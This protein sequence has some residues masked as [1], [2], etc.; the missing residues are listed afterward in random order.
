MTHQL[1][2]LLLCVATSCLA[3]PAQSLTFAEGA[4]GNLTIVTV[5]ESAPNGA[6]TT[7]LQNVELLPIE[8][9]GR[10]LAQQHDGTRSRRV[11]RH[12]I[13]RVELPG[14]GRVFRYRRASGQ[15][16]GFLQVAADGGARVVL[17]L[18]GVGAALA[19][20]FADRV[21][22]DVDGMHLAVPL[23]AGGLVLVRL[24]GGAFASTG[25]ADR[26]VAPTE[27]VEEKSVTVGAGTVW[28]QSQGNTL[29]RCAFADG[30]VPADVSPPPVANGELED[31]MAIA[32]DGSVVVFLYGPDDQQ[33]L[34]RIGA[35]G[36][37]TVLPPGPDKY[38]EPGYLPEEP[39]E[40]ALLLADDGSRLFFVDSEPRDELWLLDTTGVLPPLQITED[41]RFQPYI[42]SHILPRFLG[43]RLT[44]AIGDPA[45]MD[46]FAADLANGGT[47]VNLTNTGGVPAPFAAGTIAPADA[48]AAG[49]ALLVADAQPT[50]VALR[51]IDLVAGGLA[52]LEQGVT[53]APEPG[54]AVAGVTPDVV[55]ATTAGE[56]LYAGADGALLAP[57]PPGFA[58]TPPVHGDTF[59]A[60]WLSIVQGW[61]AVFL[62][63]PGAIVSGPIEFGVT[64]LCA[65]ASRGLVVVGG[66]TPVRYHAPG[67]SVVLNRPPVAVRLCLSGAGG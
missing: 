22:V 55:V 15:A 49:S 66:S 31:Q 64:Q 42:G 50:G 37:A 43:P 56:R 12:G 44:V 52:T 9:T 8:I 3:L 57:L 33:R 45:Q 20:P 26:L 25:R 6:A 59:A 51:R 17:E 11:V 61:G 21:A 16:W 48:V 2:A 63:V 60:T 47:V 23:L 32:R 34:W 18:P 28:F 14:G 19:D 7:L 5:A 38:E 35:S 29:W 58:I 1:E 24:D 27:L 67:L 4:P 13:A 53:G 10:T 30:A 39:G 62:Y 40:P 65:T 36:P 46:W 41:A 54:S